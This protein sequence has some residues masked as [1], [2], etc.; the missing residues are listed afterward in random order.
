MVQQ[1]DKSF[2]CFAKREWRKSQHSKG[3]GATVVTGRHDPSRSG[4][5]AG[6]SLHTITPQWIFFKSIENWLTV[7]NRHHPSPLWRVVTIRPDRDDPPTFPYTPLHRNE[8]FLSQ[9]KTDEPSRTVTICHGC[10]GSSRS[11]PIGTIRWHFLTH[12]YTAMNIF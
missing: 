2:G 11:V 7:A 3:R 8:Y 9:S 12:H 1:N 10:D 4:R 5:S 6:I